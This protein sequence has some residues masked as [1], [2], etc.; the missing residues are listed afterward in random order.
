MVE[1]RSPM[2]L[3]FGMRLWLNYCSGGKRSTPDQPDVDGRTPLSYAAMFGF[4]E[5][6]ELLLGQ[7][8]VNPDKPDNDGRTPLSYASRGLDSFATE[9]H[10]RVM[11]ILLGREEVIPD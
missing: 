5:M 7:E 4:G 1:H 11:K 8:E 6:V 9:N 2:P 3:T 10:T